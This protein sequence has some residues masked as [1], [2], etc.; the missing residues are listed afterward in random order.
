MDAILRVRPLTGAVAS[1]LALLLTASAVSAQGTAVVTRNVNLREDPSSANPPIVLLAPPTTLTLLEPAKTNGYFHVRTGDGDEGFVWARNVEV[2][3]APPEAPTTVTVADELS[4][5]WE[6]P[7]PNET[8]F[9]GDEGHCGATGDGGDTDTNKRKNR[10]DVPSES[11]PVSFQALA[12]LRVPEATTHRSP[13]NGWTAEQLAVIAPFEGEAVTV[14]GFIFVIRLQTS[15]S[16]E[17][18]N[19]HFHH[20]A[21]THWHIALT[22][23][24]GDLEP[25]AVVVETTPRIRK[26]HPNWTTAAFKDYVKKNLPVRISGWTM[27]DPEHKNHLGVHRSTLWEIHPITKIEVFKNG[28]WVDLD[29]I[30]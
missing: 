6:K 24:F 16:G 28:T 4:P 21:N 7:E 9:D 12:S 1:C 11:H 22:E 5:D 3:S 25:K 18:T 26:D 8:S 17:S 14:E 20:A 19:C 30:Q 27:V 15:G 10:T 23:N 13:P 29:G 2:T